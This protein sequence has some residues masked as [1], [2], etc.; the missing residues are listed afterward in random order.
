MIY[1]N[2]ELVRNTQ[3][4]PHGNPAAAVITSL[5]G[6][7]RRSPRLREVNAENATRFAADP[8]HVSRPNFVPARAAS[9]CSKESQN[10]P[11]VSHMSS[12]ASIS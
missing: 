8:E 4:T 6:L 12:E 2:S 5:P 1:R 7:M 3:W 10:R 9:F 11:A